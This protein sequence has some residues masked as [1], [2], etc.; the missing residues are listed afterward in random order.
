MQLIETIDWNVK[1]PNSV[2][3]LTENEVQLHC[4]NLE[5]KFSLDESDD[6][7]EILVGVGI[8]KSK[9]DAKKN[10]KGIKKLT[11]SLTIINDIGAKRQHLVIYKPH[12]GLRNWTYMESRGV[13]IAVEISHCV[14]ER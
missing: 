5:Y 7:F 6:V 3:V 13:E 12:S 8:F 10:W 9:G 2:R 1:D 14:M 4:G 11:T